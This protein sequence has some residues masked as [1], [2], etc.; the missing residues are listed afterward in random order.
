MLVSLESLLTKRTF[1]NSTQTMCTFTSLWR[2][3]LE[4]ETRLLRPSILL[5]L[6]ITMRL[7]YYDEHTSESLHRQATEHPWFWKL[8]QWRHH[9]NDSVSDHQP[10]DCLLNRLFRPRSKKTSKLRVTGLCAGDSPGNGEF[11]AQMA[12]YTKNVSIWWRHHDN[13]QKPLHFIRRDSN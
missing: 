8:L 13:I 11:P 2:R 6:H 4:N 9:G 5:L 1:V 10:Y 3:R 7:R 12:S